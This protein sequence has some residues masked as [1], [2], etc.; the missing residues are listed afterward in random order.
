[1]QQG[2]RQV[3]GPDVAYFTVK[4]FALESGAVLPEARLAYRIEGERSSVEPILTVTAFS[5][6][7]DDL[8]WLS[9]AG[10]ALDPAK[11]WI[12]RTEMLGNGRSSSPSNTPA[13]FAGRDFPRLCQ[14]D[15]VRLQAALLDHLGIDR[16]AAVVG[17]SMGGQQALQWAALFP[18]RLRKAVAIIGMCR[19]TWHAQLFIRSGMDALRI[20]PDFMDGRYKSEPVDALRR[21][22]MLWAPWATSP[23]FFSRGLFQAYA[24]T[25]AD[26][27]QDFI[28]KWQERYRGKDANDL[29]CQMQVWH[30][31]D[32]AAGGDLAARAAGINTPLLFLPSRS[33][34]Y[35]NA[36]DIAD[37]ARLFANARCVVI[38]SDYGHA[39]GL[40]RASEDRDFCNGEMA[41]FLD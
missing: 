13:P 39:A 23:R 33:D 16:V 17:A 27:L 38:P 2:D 9:Q 29:L 4:N 6:V 3:Q 35:F 26:T 24:D 20:S 32:I 21:L 31:H 1:M 8:F 11:R 10:G 34:A 15:N 37:E 25:S 14:R 36:E 19:T 5:R 18:E 30:D 28:A 40:G 12:I 7:C 41:R 22:S